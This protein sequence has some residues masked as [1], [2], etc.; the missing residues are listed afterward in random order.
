[1]VKKSNGKMYIM[2]G[3]VEK[4]AG[5]KIPD[6]QLM[7]PKIL[8]YITKEDGPDWTEKSTNR[9]PTY[10]ICVDCMGSGPSGMHCQK[11]RAEACCCKCPWARCEYR[12]KKWIDVEWIPHML[13]TTHMDARADRIQTY[14]FLSPE[15]INRRDNRGLDWEMHIQKI[16]N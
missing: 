2:R 15:H 3:Y 14:P 9:C 4:M 10:R 8:K 1:M 6:K 16:C 5:T 13:C 7:K 12:M 11:C